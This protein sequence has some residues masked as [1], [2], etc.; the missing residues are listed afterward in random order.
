MGV[1]CGGGDSAE[2]RARSDT[3]NRWGTSLTPGD[4]IPARTGDVV[5]TVDGEISN[6]DKGD[7]A[8]FDMDTLRTLGM[9]RYAAVDHGRFGP[10]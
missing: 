2:N 1:A 7:E 8:V 10:R 6:G 5:L 4:P 3:S 9:Y